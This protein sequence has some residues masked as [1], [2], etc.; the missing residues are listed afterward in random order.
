M[1]EKPLLSGR[2]VIYTS[3]EE[4]NSGNILDVLSAALRTH[5]KNAIEE[6]YLYNYYKGIQPIINREKEYNEYINNKIVVNRANEIVSFKVGYLMGEP[7][8]YVSRRDDENVSNEIRMLN[9]YM[10][11]EG[12][13]AKDEEIANWFSIVGDRKSVV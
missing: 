11:A 10:Y 5:G 1:Y 7:I 2:T 6:A 9:D 8:Q 4:I 12:K 3:E 13:E